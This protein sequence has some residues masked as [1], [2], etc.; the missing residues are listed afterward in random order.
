MHTARYYASLFYISVY[1]YFNLTAAVLDYL[2]S[3][4]GTWEGYTL[5]EKILNRGTNNQFLI[6]T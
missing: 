1:Y 6:I 5:I 4:E 3:F 2:V